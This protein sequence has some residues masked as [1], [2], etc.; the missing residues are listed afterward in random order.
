[1]INIKDTVTLTA[2]GLKDNPRIGGGTGQ[3]INTGGGAT[4]RLIRVDFPDVGIRT[5]W[6][7][8]LKV[9]R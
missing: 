3:V 2:A 1:M 8:E 6:E 4:P 9:V 5:V 7:D